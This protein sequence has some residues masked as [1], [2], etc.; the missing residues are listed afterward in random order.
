VVCGLVTLQGAVLI[1]RWDAGDL[2]KALALIERLA[3]ATARAFAGNNLHATAEA[4]RAFRGRF[5]REQWRNVILCHRGAG[6]TL[7]ISVL[8]RIHESK[9]D[10]RQST[11][12]GKPR[13]STPRVSRFFFYTLRR[14]WALACGKRTQETIK[15]TLR[16]KQ[17][18]N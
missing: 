5:R 4:M 17:S 12:I 6:K 9:P 13:Q 16:E 1:P 3:T 7:V 11:T 14:L 10:E 8:G 18:S 2:E 15:R